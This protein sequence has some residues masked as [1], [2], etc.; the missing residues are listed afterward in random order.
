MDRGNADDI[1]RVLDL[2]EWRD[3]DYPGWRPVEAV[4]MVPDEPEPVPEPT[5]DPT[6]TPTP[7]FTLTP[8]PTPT[9]TPVPVPT[10][11]ERAGSSCAGSCP[12]GSRT[13]GLT[14]R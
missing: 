6:P 1:D 7:T 2:L 10:C 5:P 11:S 9:P 3:L 8:T 4:S 14:P 13:F 12:L